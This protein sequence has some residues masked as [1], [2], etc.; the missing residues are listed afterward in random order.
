MKPT[1]RRLIAALLLAATPLAAVA[2]DDA[3]A[4]RHLMMATFDKPEAPLTVDPVTVQGDL[5]VAGWAQGDMGGRALLR[6]E[7][8]TWELS[9]CAGEALR[10]PAG[11]AGLGMSAAEAEA[12]AAAVVAAE[13]PLDPALVAKFSSFEG[14]VT[15]S[16][17]GEHP[18]A[19]GHAGHGAAHGG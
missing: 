7:D 12:L 15:M 6:R 16:A 9:L 14:V 18:P 5:A 1:A 19:D 10:D 2:E 13:A 8:G 11:L 4:I 17:D 3:G